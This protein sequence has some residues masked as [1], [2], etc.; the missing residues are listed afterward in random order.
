MQ[1]IWYDQH[2]NPQAATQVSGLGPSGYVP[3]TEPLP[4]PYVGSDRYKE[5]ERLK[6]EIHER[7]ERERQEKNRKR[8]DDLK[9]SVSERRQAE[10]KAKSSEAKAKGSEPVPKATTAEQPNVKAKPNPF[11]VLPQRIPV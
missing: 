8:Y 3:S 2:G 4:A 9:K 6:K 1:G 11:H 7:I 5:N 10:A